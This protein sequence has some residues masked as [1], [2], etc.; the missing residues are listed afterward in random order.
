MTTTNASTSIPMP[1]YNIHTVR[2]LFRECKMSDK[3]FRT[4]T[5]SIRFHAAKN[6]DSSGFVSVE[7]QEPTALRRFLDQVKKF[8]PT[9]ARRYPY[10]WPVVAYLDLYL[11][12]RRRSHFLRHPQDTMK[13]RPPRSKPLSRVPVYIR[14]ARSEK[15]G[16]SLKEITDVGSVRSPRV[17]RA[18][19]RRAC[20]N[21]PILK[22]SFKRE[23]T[24]TEVVESVAQPVNTS[25][26]A[27]STGS[28][29]A[30][31]FQNFLRSFGSSI[32]DICANIV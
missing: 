16:R 4:L 15:T 3:E 1:E 7:E 19:S 22:R 23:T 32:G 30:S 27:P 25:P 5:T 8:H 29:F 18:P 21:E 24:A 12:R 11:N 2:V 6:L 9:I 20:R 17:S 31:P 26:P 13:W 10:L 28:I 14:F